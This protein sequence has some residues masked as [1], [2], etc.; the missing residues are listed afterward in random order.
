MTPTVAVAALE[1]AHL[2]PLRRFL[3]ELPEGDLTFIKEEIRDPAVAEGWV[4]DPGQTRIWVARQESGAVLGL[5]SIRPLVGWSAHVG[6][7]RLVVDPNARGQGV[8]R[9]LARRALRGALEAGLEK[10]VVE[11]VAEQEGA[12]RMF[13]DLGFRGE[14]VLSDHIRDREGVLRDLLVLAH[15]AGEEW[16]ALASVGVEGDVA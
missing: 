14:A 2:P 13:S 1:P 4:R 6:E 9:L 8:G 12:V 5:V 10:I 16:S 11:V 3:D 7:L 15:D